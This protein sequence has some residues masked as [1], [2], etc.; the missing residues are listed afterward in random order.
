MQRYPYQMKSTAPRPKA[1]PFSEAALPPNKRRQRKQRFVKPKHF[2]GEQHTSLLLAR[3]AALSAKK[4]H[5][6]FTAELEEARKKGHS[7]Q[8]RNLGADHKTDTAQR[9]YA[10]ANRTSYERRRGR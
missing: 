10:I 9:F 4:Q 3:L 1:E 2:R 6:R 5:V 8:Y 7:R